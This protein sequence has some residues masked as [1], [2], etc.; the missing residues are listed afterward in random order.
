MTMDSH[1]AL[2]VNASAFRKAMGSFP[3]GVTVVTVASDDGG[4]HGV[5]VNSFS[6]VSL[7][8]LL[9]L[10]CLHEASRAVGQIERGGAFGVSVL[11][12]GQQDISR[13]FANGHRPAARRCST[14]CPWN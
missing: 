5:T 13:W 14:G 6:S 3:T 11:S 12:A 4:M 10:V 2:T 1:T 7:D 8:P 9:V